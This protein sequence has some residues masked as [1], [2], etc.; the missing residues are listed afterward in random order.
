MGTCEGKPDSSQDVEHSTA[1]QPKQRQLADQAG[2]PTPAPQDHKGPFD[3]T[4]LWGWDETRIWL[5]DI[6]ESPDE[7]DNDFLFMA[8]ISPDGTV[9]QQK[10]KAGDRCIFQDLMYDIQE[11]VPDSSTDGKL[12]FTIK[13]G[14]NTVE[15]RDTPEGWT[16]TF[17]GLLPDRKGGFKGTIY[18]SWWGDRKVQVLNYAKLAPAQRQ[19]YPDLV[20][21]NYYR[22][23]PR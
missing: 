18:T 6:D 11:F 19:Q 2:T 23:R 20:T 22:S 7:T 3:L 13:F 21:E 1:D 5:C 12:D 4:K 15:R 14:D 16:V 17:K 10:A 8:S 9:C